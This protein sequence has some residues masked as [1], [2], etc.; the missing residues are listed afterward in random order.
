MSETVLAVEKP[1]RNRRLSIS[2]SD[3]WASGGDQAAG[4]GGLADAGAVDA[5]AVVLDLD[6]DAARAVR[7]G[8]VDG[9][10]GALAGG[11]APLGPSRARGRRR[12]GSG[13]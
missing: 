5:G 3:S 13:G 7:G 6:D 9:A 12:C 8:E 4:L 11:E 1:G 2:A 10:L